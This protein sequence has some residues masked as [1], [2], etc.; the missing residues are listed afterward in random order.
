MPSKAA[1]STSLQ[2]ATASM[3]IHQTLTDESMYRCL[4][5]NSTP[6]FFGTKIDEFF[7]I[8]LK[9][10]KSRT[11]FGRNEMVWP[12]NNGC[13]LRR[14]G[15]WTWSGHV[16]PWSWPLR[17]HSSR[18]NQIQSHQQRLFYA[19]TLWLRSAIP[20]VFAWHQLEN[21][22]SCRSHLFHASQ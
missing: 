19:A 8:V 11:F 12:R 2:T 10:L 16:L 7:D 17:Q 1:E 18:R 15:R 4:V 14:P 13:Q 21:V 6:T 22:E 9:H 20:T 5:W 3:N